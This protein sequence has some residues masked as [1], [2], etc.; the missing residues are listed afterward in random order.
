MIRRPPRSTLFPYTTLFRS[1][2]RPGRVGEA[3]VAREAPAARETVCSDTGQLLGA[4]EPRGPDE[5]DGDHDDVGDDLAE[6]AAQEEQLLLVAGGEGLGQPDE[7]S[8]HQRAAG[9][10]QAEIGRASCRE[11]V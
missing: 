3:D 4:E 8:A 9:G 1:P 5:Q 11:R 10:V 7:Q 2:A 6:A